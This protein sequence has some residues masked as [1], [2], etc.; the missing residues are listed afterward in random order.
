MS[1][2]YYCG[3]KLSD[4]AITVLYK[5][6]I[7]DNT[8]TGNVLV[9]VYMMSLHVQLHLSCA[10]III[11]GSAYMCLTN[12]TTYLFYEVNQ[13]TNQQNMLHKDHLTNS[14]ERA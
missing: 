10:Y 12:N 14:K 13:D 3:H 4:G 7:H 1:V 5:S 9:A 11:Y 6:D 8:N 2:V